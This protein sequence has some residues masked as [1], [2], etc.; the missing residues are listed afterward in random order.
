MFDTEEIMRN[1]P[2]R[3]PFLLIDRVCEFAAGEAVTT[4]K[5]ITINEAQF[6]GHFPG[7]PVFPGVYIIENM[8]QSACFLLAKSAGGLKANTVYYLGRV[9]KMA[10]K[11]PVRP[12]DQLITRIALEKQ[13]GTN[14]MVSAVSRVDDAIIAKGDLMFAAASE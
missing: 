5:N 7:N 3:Y 4:L 11:K 8:A 2:H 13:M 1:V 6:Q 10:F 9:M 14:A 12:G